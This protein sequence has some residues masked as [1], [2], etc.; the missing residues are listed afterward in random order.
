MRKKKFTGLLI[1]GDFNYSEIDWSSSYDIP[2]PTLGSNVLDLVLSN[3]RDRI[4][5]V[6]VNAP[7]GGSDKNNLHS[8]L[9]WDFITTS[10]PFI[11][12]DPKPCWKNGN[13]EQFSSLL[14]SVNWQSSL[15]NPTSNMKLCSVHTIQVCQS[16]FLVTLTL[17]SL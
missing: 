2:E 10:C 5:A 3:S 8:V 4:F 16:L 6:K 14:N 12:T 17:L 9:T 15:S 11:P 7:L 13:Y 1:T